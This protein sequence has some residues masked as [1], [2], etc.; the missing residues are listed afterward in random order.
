MARTELLHA[1][2]SAIK[3]RR[4]K[5]IRFNFFD[6]FVVLFTV[7]FAL[8]CFYPMWYVFLASITP[9]SE[10]IQSKLMVWFPQTIDFQYYVAVFSTEVFANAL[11]ISVVKTV[12]GTLLSV[13]VTSMMAY[14]VSKT[15]IRGMTAINALVVFTLLFSGGLIPE[16]MLYNQIGILRT[17]WVMILPGALSVFYFIIMR[18]YFA[19]S[20][21][22]ELEEAAMIDGASEF[23]IFFQVI[24]PTAKP[25]L[26]AV[27]LFIA[28]YHWN[29]FYSYMMFISNKP[30]LQPF[31]WILRRTLV[32][33][34]LMNQIRNEAVSTGM[35]VLPPI[36]LRMATIIIAM[37]PILMIYPF[38]QRFFAK[39]MLL[40]AVKE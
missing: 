1:D 6:V 34:S 12:I 3:V 18:N 16:Y 21:P 8:V 31:A 29:D 2:G 13:L 7:S 40:G 24:L 10:F 4:R 11:F 37:V 17:F 9:Y 23:R 28:V 32:D 26:A 36:G 33:P 22:K 38:L 39:G 27:A 30:D 19:Y 25:M 20:A 35:P 15:H 14:A 5:L